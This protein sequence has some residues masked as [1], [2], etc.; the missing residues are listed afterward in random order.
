MES[1]TIEILKIQ[2]EIFDIIN[3]KNGV[4]VH[5]RNENEG[6]SLITFNKKNNEFFLLKNING[7]TDNLEDE[8]GLYDEI[9]SYVKELVKCVDNKKSND[10]I[11]NSFTVVWSRNN[12]KTQTS[13]FYGSDVEDVINKFFYGK[14]GVKHL[15]R[16]YEIKMNPLE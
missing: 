2:N 16:I 8:L 6:L 4:S 13:Y 3:A 10:T 5:F 12:E 11:G 1:T 15:F 9:L 14:E 7:E